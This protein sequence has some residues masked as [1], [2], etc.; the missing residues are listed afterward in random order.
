LGGVGLEGQGGALFVLGEAG[1]G[2][3]AVIEQ[4]GHLAEPDFKISLG[5]GDPMETMLAFGVLS[6]SMQ[7][8]GGHSLLE[9][10]PAGESST[11]RRTAQCFAVRRWL[12]GQAG[13]L[14]WA[15]DDLHWADADS[16]ALISF[17]CRRVSSLPVAVIGTL[18]PWPSAA[19]ELARS[20][21]LSGA[22]A[23]ELLHPL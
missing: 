1:L 19:R 20:L 4:A 10:T 17:L 15:L 23:V 8:L 11:D 5:R 3:T 18:R 14:L 22:A 9:P 12:E 7:G 21:T 13:P 2:K 6:Q 16:L